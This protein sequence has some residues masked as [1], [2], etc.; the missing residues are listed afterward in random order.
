MGFPLT[1]I[2]PHTD[3]SYMYGLVGEFRVTWN[4]STVP[5]RQLSCNTVLSRNQNVCKLG[6]RSSSE[7]SHAFINPVHSFHISN[8]PRFILYLCTEPFLEL[9]LSCSV[10]DSISMVWMLSNYYTRLLVHSVHPAAPVLLTKNGPQGNL[11]CC[12]EVL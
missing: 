2:L 12:E 8:K 5:L 1:R 6:S 9:C 10:S 7:W 11:I 3:F 4:I